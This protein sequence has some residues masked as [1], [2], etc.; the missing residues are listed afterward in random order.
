MIV[1]RIPISDY[2]ILQIK[3]VNVNLVIIISKD[4]R[5]VANVLMNVKHAMIILNVKHVE[6]QISVI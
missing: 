4:S 3:D 1:G 5:S 2:G 6:Q